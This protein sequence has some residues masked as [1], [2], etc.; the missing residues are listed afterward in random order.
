MFALS[1][2]TGF[3]ANAGDEIL[4]A[5]TPYTGNGATQS[6]ITRQNITPGALVWLKEVGATGAHGLFDTA[7][8][9][10]AEINIDSLAEATVSG[11]TA[12]NS[13]GFSLG[14]DAVYN[15]NADTFLALSWLERAGYMDIVTWSGTD[16]STL[17]RSHNLGAVPKMM[18][19]KRRNSSGSNFPTYH[20][21][22]SFALSDSVALGDNA[23]SIGYNLTTGVAPTSSQFTV[24]GSYN[25]SGGDYVAHLFAELAGYSKFGSYTGTA[26]ALAVTGVN[27]QPNA[28]LIK[29]TDTSADWTL[30]YKDGG[31]IYYIEPNTTVAR[32]TQVDFAFT[33]DGFSMN[34]A[35]AQMNASAGNYIYAAWK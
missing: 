30:F 33:S 14:S 27:F 11:V 5:A 25:Q 10:T 7:R 6:I 1:H 2:L 29:R 31:S 12:F 17:T 15:N 23:G 24:E 34:N 26:G 22:A 9:A 21:S 19:F 32:A 4:F 28:V 13:D 20:A 8:G 16:G 18:V 3:N 35:V